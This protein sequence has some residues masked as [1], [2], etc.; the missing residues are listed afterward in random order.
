MLYFSSV[1][2]FAPSGGREPAFPAS[3]GRATRHACYLE[4][5]SIKAQQT[6]EEF[7]VVVVVCFLPPPFLLKEIQTEKPASGRKP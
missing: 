2:D 6:Q 3:P 5:K 1:A 7:F 4:L